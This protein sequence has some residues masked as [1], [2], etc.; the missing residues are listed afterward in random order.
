MKE[1][2]KVMTFRPKKSEVELIKKTMTEKRISQTEAIHWLFAEGEFLRQQR[3]TKLANLMQDF[4]QCCFPTNFLIY[5]EKERKYECIN[6]K[7]LVNTKRLKEGLIPQHC[8]ACNKEAKRLKQEAEELTQYGKIVTSFQNTTGRKRISQKLMIVGMNKQIETLEAQKTDSKRL[9]EKKL[10]NLR[11]ERDTLKTQR[12]ELR[13]K[14]AEFEKVEQEFAEKKALLKEIKEYGLLE[15]ENKR[16]KAQNENLLTEKDT[17]KSRVSDLENTLLMRDEKI[18]KLERDNEQFKLKVEKLSESKLLDENDNLRNQLTQK[19]TLIDD[20]KLEIR[21]LE[22]LLEEEL[23]P[24]R[25]VIKKVRK[26]LRDLKEYAPSTLEPYEAISYLRGVRKTIES[27]E[28][29]LNTIEVR[30]SPFQKRD[31]I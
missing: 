1:K 3:E 13:R 25:D 18:A 8:E 27:L 29:Y 24:R 17:L 7:P 21:K 4:P 20:Y 10:G 12:N 31:V 2:A 16:L 11:A 26:M 22:A 28:G 19:N 30:E 23:K 14:Y 15:Q 5:L 9:Y 6:P